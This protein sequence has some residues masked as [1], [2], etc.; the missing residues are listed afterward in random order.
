[1]R[2]SAVVFDLDGTLADT[3]ADIAAAG[4]HALNA[5]GRPPRPVEDYRLLA[6]QGLRS[7]VVEALGDPAPDDLVERGMNTFLTY[8][9]RHRFDHTRAYDGVTD[10]LDALNARGLRLGVLSNKP[11]HETLA[12][13]Q[14]LLPRHRFDAVIGHQDDTPLKPDPTSAR[15]LMASLGVRPEECVYVGDTKVDMLTGRSAGMFTIGVTWGFREEQELRQH[16]AEAIIHE[17]MDLLELLH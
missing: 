17:P 13:T 16:G 8:Y 10:L 15:Q 6:G 5:L 9:A 2:R 7:L 11:H 3:L 14:A 1:M 4:N 12:V